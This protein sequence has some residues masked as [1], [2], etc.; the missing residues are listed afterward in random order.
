[1]IRSALAALLITMAAPVASA[2]FVPGPKQAFP[3]F[4]SI[5]SPRPDVP[6]GALWIEGFGPTGEGASTDNLETIRSLNGLTIDRNLQ[7]S[8][9]IG[10]FDLIGIEPRLRDHFTAR[11]TDLTIVRVK[12]MERLKGPPGEPRIIEALKAGSIVVSSD[13]EA[14]LNVRGGFEV[15]RVDG[16][17]TNSRT[18]AYSIEGRDMFIAICKRNM[19]CS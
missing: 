3:G 8:L 15:T 16:S 7:V 5:S 19:V 11:F 9:I 18:R 17:T 4:V 1:M 14:G 10:L 6:I 13:G 12:D 2:D